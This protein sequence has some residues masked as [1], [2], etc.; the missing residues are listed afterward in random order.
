MDNNEEKEILEN[1]ESEIKEEKVEVKKPKKKFSFKNL[2]KNQKIILIGAIVFVLIIATM[3]I[4]YFFVFSKSEKAKT[5]ESEDIVIQMSNY[6]YENGTL[7]FLDDNDL[8][9]GSY[10]CENK[11]ENL[12]RVAKYNQEDKL[13]NTKYILDDSDDKLITF[14]L[15]IYEDKYVFIIDSNE[16]EYL[17]KLYDIKINEF[18]GEYKNVKKYIDN[19]L[20]VQDETNKYGLINLT[21]E[22]IEVKLEFEYDYLGLYENATNLAFEQDGSYGIVNIDGNVLAT[23][24]SEIS[25]YNDESLIIVKNNDSY[26]L[27]NYMNEKIIEDS[28]DFIIVKNNY[29]EIIN[30]NKLYLRANNG[31]KI[32]EEGIVVTGNNHVKQ[33]VMSS[34]YQTVSSSVSYTSNYE[35]AGEVLITIE[36]KT[37]TLNL[38]EATIN[39]NYEYVNYIDGIIYIYSDSNKENLAGS[40]ECETKNTINESSTGF[41]N[42]FIATE[43]KL[44]NRDNSKDTLGLIPI[45]NNSL[46]FIKDGSVINLY[47]YISDKIVAPYT[48]VDVGYY[49]S[50]NKIV[51]ATSSDLLVMAIN[52]TSEAGIF[53][54]NGSSISK[55]IA[56]EYE[57]IEKLNDGYVAKTSSGEYDLYSSDG[58]NPTEDTTIK[59]EIIDYVSGYMKVKSSDGKFLV[60]SVSGTI[61][62]D[63]LKNI[64]LGQSIFMGITDQNEI[65]VYKYT[66]GKNNILSITLPATSDDIKFTDNGSSGFKIEFL[67][68]SDKVIETYN[69]DVNGDEK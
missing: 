32:N 43:S 67:N 22:T 68:E 66:S 26:N 49:N 18:L 62:S 1:E 23:I 8:E 38:Y 31:T 55:F 35:V 15:P 69:F 34:D 21:S 20:I 24:S 25:S 2:T 13:S 11:D 28:K 39:S 60:Y 14:D 56:F 63:A 57:S 54:L 46:A 40:Y 10:E 45:Y 9:I 58:E 3:V 12:C 30:D 37:K 48:K 42:C 6:R 29:V 33:V 41:D 64:K 4:L 51:T 53:K 16:E 17:I 19:G 44:L 61:I 50:E 47:N 5:N 36:E 52:K 27:V 65:E 7:I 59:S